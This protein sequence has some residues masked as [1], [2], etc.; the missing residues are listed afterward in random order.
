MSEKDAK[1]WRKL[2]A[3]FPPTE[4]QRGH[5]CLL[6][7]Q[8]IKGNTW[9][10][11]HQE[12][13]AL[14]LPIIFDFYYRLALFTTPGRVYSRKQS[15][16]WFSA[17]HV[18]QVDLRKISGWLGLLKLAP[19][20]G[21]QA[22][23]IQPFCQCS[24][25]QTDLVT[26]HV[27][28]DETLH[29]PELA[30]KGLFLTEFL[31]LVFEA[32]RRLK[33]AVGFTLYPFVSAQAIACQKKPEIFDSAAEGDRWFFNFVH[34]DAKEYLVQVCQ[35]YARTYGFDFVYYDF[36][37]IEEKLNTDFWKKLE[38][39]SRIVAS[40]AV[41]GGTSFPFQRV[42][43]YLI[44]L[45]PD[46]LPLTKIR[47]QDVE[48]EIL[49][50][51][52]FLAI[53]TSI[54]PC[55]LTCADQ[56]Y[57]RKIVWEPQGNLPIFDHKNTCL[58]QGNYTMW[59]WGNKNEVTILLVTW[60]PQTRIEIDLSSWIRCDSFYQQIIWAFQGNQL[61]Y[62]S[63]ELL[64]GTCVVFEDLSASEARIILVKT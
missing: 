12:V 25:G 16:N 26:S 11:S 47:M 50:L 34:L 46:S 20:F 1:N 6:Y 39:E 23:V 43:P 13:L 42:P 3:L 37:S 32:L 38:D 36:S 14:D 40:F 63:D 55:V 21:H 62:L 4:E 49:P 58:D 54:F 22:V 64:S 9:S 5:A 56:E 10:L 19:L 44:P 35:H 61:D 17:M 24:G 48:P 28:L 57:F 53:Y 30:D 45:S 60:R 41:L 29:A 7:Q 2:A 31:P 59:V 51:I 33:I 8:F 15:T 27:S 52:S 18:Y